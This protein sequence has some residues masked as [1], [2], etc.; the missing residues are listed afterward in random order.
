MTIIMMA[1]LMRV[2]INVFERGEIYLHERGTI[3]QSISYI[4]VF[5]IIIT[6]I[7]LQFT[8]E[9]APNIYLFWG[10]RVNFNSYNNL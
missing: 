7:P 6:Q 4:N 2:L 5:S 8:W 9:N 3:V 1:A 10:S